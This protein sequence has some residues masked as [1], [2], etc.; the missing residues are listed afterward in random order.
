MGGLSGV[1]S[2]AEGL[3]LLLVGV[4]VVVVYVC[5]QERGGEERNRAR[6]PARRILLDI[7]SS[8]Q[9]QDWFLSTSF[10][11]CMCMCVCVYLCELGS[12]VVYLRQG[13]QA[14]EEA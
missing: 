7:S 5:V 13:T 10:Q 11:E 1:D 2:Q 12:G 6:Q 4:V 14:E 3:L 9:L 8:M